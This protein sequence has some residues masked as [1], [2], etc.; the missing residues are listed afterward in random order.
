MICAEERG[1]IL[2]MT[3]VKCT[4]VSLDV[5]VSRRTIEI[6]C[7]HAVANVLDSIQHGVDVA[8]RFSRGNIIFKFIPRWM[9]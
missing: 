3:N 1:E 5:W 7:G 4:T 8:V 2:V 6:A 9:G